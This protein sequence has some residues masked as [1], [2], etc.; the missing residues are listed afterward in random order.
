MSIFNTFYYHQFS[1]KPAHSIV[2]YRPFFFP[3]D[4]V[5]HWNRLYGR[6]GF[7]QYQ[8]VVPLSSGHDSIKE[9]LEAILKAKT[10][11]F[12]AVLKRLGAGNPLKPLSFPMEGYTLALD[13]CHTPKALAL[14]THLDEIV[15]RKGGRIYLAK[16]ARMS[17][18]TLKSGYPDLDK[19]ITIK[20]RLDPHNKI[21]SQLSKRLNIT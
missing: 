8:C 17:T 13:F 12:L 16:D 14:L 18:G 20:R 6:R 7:L 2:S 9:I 19:L 3:L 4:S 11:S 5:G 1:F 15:E 10:G 21:E